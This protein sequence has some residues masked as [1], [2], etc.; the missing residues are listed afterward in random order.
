MGAGVAMSNVPSISKAKAGAANIFS[1]IDELSTLDVRE[2]T[3]EKMTEIEQGEID[4]RDVTFSYPSR[5]T[6]VL[7]NF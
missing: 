4:F 1:I 3:A 6:T 7:N 2:Q 5:K